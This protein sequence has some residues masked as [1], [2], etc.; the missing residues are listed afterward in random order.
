MQDVVI[1]A[2]KRT[3]MGSLNGALVTKSASEL[4]SAAILAVLND[5]RLPTESIDEVFMGIVLPAG[6]GQAPARQA[7]LGA[8]ISHS[9]PCTAISKVCGSGMQSV[10]H[11]VAQILSGQSQVVV[12]GG[13]ESMSNAP[14]LAPKMRNGAR[15]GHSQF[16]DHMFMDG[17]EDASSNSTL[18]GVFAEKCAQKYA[19]SRSQQDDYALASLSRARGFADILSGEITEIGIAGKPATVVASDEQPSKAQPENIPRLKP[20]FG[21]SGTVTAANASSISDGAAALVLASRTAAEKSGAPIRAR[22]LATSTHAQEPC[23][24]TTAK[25]LGSS[26]LDGFRS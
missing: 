22:I 25:T 14:Y 3:P 17:L 8:G 2:A 1:C 10:R 7:S 6:V 26:G 5:S 24:F 12:A 18:M 13:M 19:F 23:W 4:G 16:F 21:T 15:I 11:A 20:A 9:V